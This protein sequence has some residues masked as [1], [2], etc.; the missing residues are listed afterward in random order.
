MYQKP[1]ILIAE[2]DDFDSRVIAKLRK[3]AEVDLSRCAEKDIPEA[4]MKYDVF[5]FRLAYKIDESVL[6]NEA[7]RCKI[8]ATPVTGIDHI[9]E[10]A[11]SKYGVSIAC[12]RGEYDFLKTIRATAEITIGLT[13]SLMRHIPAAS[14]SV[15]EGHWNRD[16]FRGNELYG[17]TAGI[18]GFGRLGKIVAE[19]FNALGMDILVYD[20]KK[21]D[22]PGNYTISQSINDLVSKSDVV[23]LHVS[24]TPNTHHLINDIVFAAFKQDAFLINTSRGDVIDEGALLKALENRKIKGAALDVLHGEPAINYSNSLLEFA[25]KNTNLLI[26]PHIGGNTFES[27]QKTEDFIADKVLK[28]LKLI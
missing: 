7:N 26:V 1:K 24:Y 28:L 3:Y 4:L 5:W 2:P 12:L 17:K 25:R 13:L 6:S 22:P 8:L 9:D 10:K 27:F 20:V 15:K 18:I 11:C 23:S 21:I 19:Y 16:L 14:F